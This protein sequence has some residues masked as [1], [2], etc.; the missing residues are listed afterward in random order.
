M[1]TLIISGSG[2]I[3]TITAPSGLAV[4]LKSIQ[5]DMPMSD[6]GTVD[7]V[8]TFS[9]VYNG[10]FNVN[11]TVVNI[12]KRYGNEEEV[13]ISTSAFGDNYSAIISYIYVGD[14]PTFLN[15]KFRMPLPQSFRS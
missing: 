14:S 12:D 2:A 4:M 8:V 10:A 11:S 9:G 15:N 3:G 13:S 5:I 6:I 1:N 7:P